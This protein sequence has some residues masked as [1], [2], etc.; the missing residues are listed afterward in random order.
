M[1]KKKV[2]VY[3]GGGSKKDEIMTALKRRKYRRLGGTAY[4]DEEINAI[5]NHVLSKAPTVKKKKSK[6]KSSG[7]QLSESQNKDYDY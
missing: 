5:S 7:L 6:K 4:T 3:K 2:K 1:K